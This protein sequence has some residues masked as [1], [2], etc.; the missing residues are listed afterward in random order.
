[1]SSVLKDI[2][3]DL[4]GLPADL[5]AD[6]KKLVE[7]AKPAV[8]TTL[9]D[10]RTRGAAVGTTL[11]GH[12]PDQFVERMP[13]AIGDRLPTTKSHGSRAKK[14]LLL[15]GLAGAVAAVAAWMRRGSAPMQPA[16]GAYPPAS[17]NNNH[18]GGA[19][20]VGSDPLDLPVEE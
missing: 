17:A 10:A 1:M 14:L 18:R 5:W 9:N 11:M 7:D 4:D 15:G 20:A 16:A 8:G 2:K 19:T 13:D 12:V 3:E 6:V